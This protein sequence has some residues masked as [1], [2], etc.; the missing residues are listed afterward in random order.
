MCF[1]NA[2]LHNPDLTSVLHQELEKRLLQAQKD[3]KLCLKSDI[4]RLTISSTFPMSARST[5]VLP[6]L[7]SQA[8]V[9]ALS[10]HLTGESFA[11]TLRLLM[12]YANNRSNS[13]WGCASTWLAATTAQ[14]V[15]RVD[16]AAAAQR[17]R[18]FPRRAHV[19][20]SNPG[21]VSNNIS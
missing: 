1:S 8:S 13:F 12:K 3:R 17:Q 4:R 5:G 2:T 6:T 20:C 10:K 18:T 19:C 7:V 15:F 11:R 14:Q 16:S 9:N 21:N